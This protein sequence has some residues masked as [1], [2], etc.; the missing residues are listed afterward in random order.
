[1]EQWDAYGHEY[2]QH[3]PYVLSEAPEQREDEER[4]KIPIKNSLL[5]RFYDDVKKEVERKRE[6]RKKVIIALVVLSL[7]PIPI[8]VISNIFEGSRLDRE[9]ETKDADS[10]GVINAL[11]NCEDSSMQFEVDVSGGE[12]TGCTQSQGGDPYSPIYL[13]A[14]SLNRNAQQ[15]WWYYEDADDF[16][17]FKGFDVAQGHIQLSELTETGRVVILHLMPFDGVEWG[18]Y[19]SHC[20]LSMN[21]NNNALY[22]HIVTKSDEWN[23]TQGQYPIQILTVITGY[24]TNS[25]ETVK[26]TLSES[27]TDNESHAGY[28]DNIFFWPIAY[29]G[30]NSVSVGGGLTADLETEFKI[31]DGWGALFVID[32]QGYVVAREDYGDGWVDWNS[33][34]SVVGNSVNGNTENLRMPHYR[35]NGCPY[36]KD[37]DYSWG[38]GVLNCY[39]TMESEL[40]FQGGGAFGVDEGVALYIVYSSIFLIVFLFISFIHPKLIVRSVIK[41]AEVAGDIGDFAHALAILKAYSLFYEKNSKLSSE[42]KRLRGLVEIDKRN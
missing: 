34:D 6:N 7:L 11:D 32:S 9:W 18:G 27:C 31:P 2:Y 40:D 25:F 35:R 30:A 39:P 42:Y 19:E 5:M 1:M 37:Y 24:S 20:F 10:D 15:N 12:W 13:T 3:N 23:N 33:F 21:E 36:D 17:D 26:S 41:R 22:Q 38:G 4:P 14:R 8:G 28:P 16:N 29:G